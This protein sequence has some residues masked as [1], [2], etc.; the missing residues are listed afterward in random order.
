M[1]L[2]K[3]G[4]AKNHRRDQQQENKPTEE[5]DDI[6]MVQLL[7]DVDFTYTATANDKT[8]CKVFAGDSG[9]QEIVP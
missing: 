7:H 6:F 2:L 5:S 1:I 4:Q 3:K 8:V 9:T